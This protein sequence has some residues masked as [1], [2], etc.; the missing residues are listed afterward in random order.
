MQV[1]YS[2]IDRLP[3]RWGL[4]TLPYSGPAG[5]K[6]ISGRFF[7]HALHMGQVKEKEAAWEVFKWLAKPENGGRFVVT[8]GHATS[9]IV[10]GGSD[11]A[12]KAYLDRSGVDAKA[13]V[14][15]AHNQVRAEGWGMW[16]YATANQVISE[17]SKH[18][19]EMRA[20]NMSVD[21]YAER[22]ARIVNEQ[23]V[24]KKR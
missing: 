23:L 2:S 6:N 9:P 16:R 8:A 20:G 19:R 3:F 4:A 10:K 1:F 15:M 14:L 17:I 21:E 13:Y 7:C 12:Q 18:Y 11:A 24:P 22:A 5:T